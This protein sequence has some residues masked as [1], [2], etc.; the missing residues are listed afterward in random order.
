[1]I[2]DCNKTFTPKRILDKNK[3]ISTD[4][5]SIILIFK[6]LLLA[7]KKMKE[8][9]IVIW[10]TKRPGGWEQ[11]GKL[12]ESCPEFDKINENENI[13]NTEAFDKIMKIQKKIKYQAFGKVKFKKRFVDNDLKKMYEERNNIICRINDDKETNDVLEAL[14]GKIAKQIIV[15]QRKELVEDIAEIQK[16]KKKSG[17]VGAVFN[18]KNRIL[19]NKK[20]PERESNAVINF[21][22]KELEVSPDKIRKVSLEYVVNLLKND[23]PDSDV[24]DD[25]ELTKMVHV[26]RQLDRSK[27]DPE[28][29]LNQDDID[30]AFEQMKKK[31]DK[32]KFILKA[33]NNFK[34]CLGNLYQKVWTS[35]EK[36]Q[37]WRNTT[38]I[39]LYKGKGVKEDPDMLRNIHTKDEYSKGFD[40]IIVNK[41][42]AKMIQKCSKFQ[43][44]AIQG[45][46]PQEHLFTLKSM[47]A[48]HE[49]LNK[50]LI[51]QLYDLEKYFDKELLRDAMSSLHAA[52]VRGKLY[53]LWYL[54]TCDNQIRVLSSAGMT[55]ME[56]T[57]ENVGQG[58]IGGAIL[59]SLNL[60]V[61][62]TEGFSESCHEVYYGGI[63]RLNPLLFQDDSLR[64]ATSAV[65][66]Q[67]GNN[68]M[69]SVMKRK[70]LNINDKSSFMLCGKPNQIKSI[71]EAIKNNPLSIKG[72]PVKQKSKEKYLGDMISSLGVSDSVRMTLN[73]RKGRILSSIFELS[74]ILEDFRM[75]TAGGLMSGLNIWRFGLLPSLLANAESWTEIPTDCMQS[76][77]SIQN[78]LL[79]KIF[80]VP[81]TTPNAALRW[82][83]GSISLEM[84]INKKK[85]LFLYHLIKMDEK[86]LAKEIFEV[87]VNK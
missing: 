63:I 66:A 51:V 68:I 16:L 19:G 53:R 67:Y 61:G 78:L 29:N 54:M 13:S 73:D 27:D 40:Q 83:T 62:V 34:N 9:Q 74:S 25:V 26:V 87:Q 77:E 85:L 58:T 18:V 72:Q 57:G 38:F 82:D 23:E 7:Q 44:G 80:S 12:M 3:V 49:L 17:Q 33:G 52:D 6:N 65:T 75:Q 2:I 46:R 59:S 70:L 30:T 84:Q 81:K 76:F 21:K 39:Q 35:E 64:L 55:D 11:Y 15:S 10:N 5:P 45:H 43:I 36:P 60:D 32:Y 79:Q 48:Y 4:H 8:E 20:K 56:P 1:M 37:Q 31:G 69:E 42:K 71:Q 50:P 28:D 41:S 47:M 24:Q 22:T 14:D 86:S